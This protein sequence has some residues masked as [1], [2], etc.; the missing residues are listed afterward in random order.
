MTLEQ[1]ES[2][3]HLGLLFKKKVMDK[4]GLSIAEAAHTLEVSEEFL[5]DFIAG[6]VNSTHEFAKKLADYTQ[7]AVDMWLADDDCDLCD[8]EDDYDC[9]HGAGPVLAGHPHQDD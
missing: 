7:T 2:D 4:M 1:V 6:N 5:E 9:E 8:D 3:M